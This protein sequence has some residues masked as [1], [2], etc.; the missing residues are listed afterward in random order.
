MAEPLTSQT[1]TSRPDESLWRYPI[2]RSL[3]CDI[4]GY[5]YSLHSHFSQPF[6]TVNWPI[7]SR[8]TPFSLQPHLEIK[9]KPSLNL[10]PN[11]L[12][13]NIQRL[14]RLQNC[15]SR[16][17]SIS[18]IYSKTFLPAKLSE[19]QIIDI[20]EIFKAFP[21]SK[22]Y[23]SSSNQ[24]KQPATAFN[25][26]NQQQQS[27]AASSSSNQQQRPAAAT[28]IS[29]QLQQPAAATSFHPST[30]THATSSIHPTTSNCTI[31]ASLC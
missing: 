12:G 29:N 11:H 19:P 7:S 16:K 15:L 22:Q 6:A 13:E 3:D 18:R 27:T 9:T 31:N 8:R 5:K 4:T 28:S 26:S 1:P 10:F 14:F 17:S 30:S 21:A 25:S 20:L 2:G 24:Q 23:P